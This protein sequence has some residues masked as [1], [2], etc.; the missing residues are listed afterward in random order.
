MKLRNLQTASN[1]KGPFFLCDKSQL[2][3][4]PCSS[5]GLCNQ[6]ILDSLLATNRFVARFAVAFV[7]T[8]S[9]GAFTVFR[10]KIF[11]W[12]APV[13]FSSDNRGYGGCVKENDK[14]GK[15]STPLFRVATKTK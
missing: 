1:R 2:K 8:N 4:A 6:P 11:S 13:D 9:F 10:Q 14:R 7:I 15:E 3:S 5:Y 12:A